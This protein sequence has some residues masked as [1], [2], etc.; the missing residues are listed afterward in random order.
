MGR[1][2][3]VSLSVQLLS[4]TIAELMFISSLKKL[5]LQTLPFLCVFLFLFFSP[6]SNAMAKSKFKSVINAAD[7]AIHRT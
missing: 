4:Q 3:D 5:A 2:G 1:K 6:S 7:E